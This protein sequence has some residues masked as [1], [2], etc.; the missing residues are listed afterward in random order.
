MSSKKLL[1][2][3]SKRLLRVFFSRVLM[4]SYLILRSFIHFEFI[5]VYGVRKWYSFILLLVAVQFFQHHLLRRLS[6]F[7]LDT[8]SCFVK[9]ELA[10]HLWVQFLV[11]YSIPL[12]YVSV[13]VPIP[14][15]LDDYSFVVEDKV[16]DSDA[17]LFGFLFFFFFNVYSY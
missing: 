15:C 4:V 11:L 9:D 1:Q 2:L 12:V 10:I 7:P 6:F 14:C 13:F 8:V 17:S 16:W 3:R 5:F